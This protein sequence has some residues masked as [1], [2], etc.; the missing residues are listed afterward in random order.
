MFLPILL[1]KQCVFCLYKKKDHFKDVRY[2]VSGDMIITF[3]LVHVV[4]KRCQ[5]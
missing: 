5:S 2:D 4:T 1:V 3:M